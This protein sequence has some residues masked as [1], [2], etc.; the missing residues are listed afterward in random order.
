M[1]NSGQ[2]SNTNTTLQA[3]PTEIVDKIDKQFIY[4]IT[5]IT[6]CFDKFTCFAPLILQVFTQILC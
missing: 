5:K 4:Y 1:F 2:D 3:K 6:R